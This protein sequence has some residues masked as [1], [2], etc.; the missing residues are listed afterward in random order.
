MD[1]EAKERFTV[2]LIGD[3][4][5]PSKIALLT[6]ESKRYG[7]NLV[8]GIGGH[9]EPEKDQTM[10]ASAVRELS[11]EVPEWVDTPLV[12]FARCGVNNEK[13][14]YYYWGIRDGEIPKADEH[15]GTLAWVL[16]TDILAQN[17]FPTTR[18]VLEE[19]VRRRFAVDR[20]WTIYVSGQKDANNVTQAVVVDKIEEGFL[21]I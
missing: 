16:V 8:T 3:C 7:G 20:P 10:L 19:W 21:E 1:T 4:Q 18:P 13:V 2:I 15:E 17:I 11:E 9:F 14:L 6:R 5:P 12:E